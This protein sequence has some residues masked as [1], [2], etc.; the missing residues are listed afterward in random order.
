MLVLHD[1]PYLRFNPV[2]QCTNSF[3]NDRGAER[4]SET[5]ALPGEIHLLCPD[6]ENRVPLELEPEFVFRRNT[7]TGVF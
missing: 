5:A 2:L 4:D 6:E 7:S 1:D 3:S